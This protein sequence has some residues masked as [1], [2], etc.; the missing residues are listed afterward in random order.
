MKL[1]FLPI[2]K[3]A[4]VKLFSGQKLTIEWS[5]IDHQSGQ[6]LT[7]EWSKIDQNQALY[8]KYYRNNNRKYYRKGRYLCYS[9]KEEL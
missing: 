3:S 4:M 5:K 2:K 9:I 7:G 8:R 6:K 1:L